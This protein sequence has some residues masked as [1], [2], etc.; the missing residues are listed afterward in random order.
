MTTNMN[1]QQPD[2]EL[3]HWRSSVQDYMSRNDDI[4][5][6]IAAQNLNRLAPADPLGL[7]GLAKA[8]RHRGELEPA[9][10]NITQARQR[11]AEPVEGMLL[12]EAQLAQQLNQHAVAADRYAE[13][14]ALN[15]LEPGYVT[16]RADALRLSGHTEE[17]DKEL[18]KGRDFFQYDQA[19]H[20]SG[21]AAAVATAEKDAININQK[22]AYLNAEA[23]KNAL[24]ILR[25]PE[26][27]E[28]V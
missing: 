21:V 15:P 10:F 26:P 13:L 16:A 6:Y 2:D 22:P 11:S 28:S 14:I 5:L 12:L 1:T 9:Y 25:K 23:A 3:Q 19:L 20:D 27:L 17:A 18:R 8:Q 24:E 4:N 7:F